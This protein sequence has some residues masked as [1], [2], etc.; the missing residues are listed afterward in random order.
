VFSLIGC[1]QGKVIVEEYDLKSLFPM[2]L[3]CHY[4][5]HFLAKSKRGVV[6]QRVE[7]DNIL[8]IFEMTTNTNE[9]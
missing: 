1:E 2:F 3:K 4:D 7:K 9:Q 5:L 6:D 8:D